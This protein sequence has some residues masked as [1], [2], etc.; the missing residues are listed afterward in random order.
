MKRPLPMAGLM[1]CFVPGMCAQEFDRLNGGAF[2]DYFGSNATGTNMFGVGRRLGFGVFP[3]VKLEDEVAYLFEQEFA[4][5]FTST[6]G[7]TVTFANTGVRA[8]NELFG[9][10]LELGHGN[11][12]PF[13]GIEGR[14][15]GLFV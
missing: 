14:V 4:S 5:G 3:H 2:A 9:P 7:R 15:R 13:F 12:R 10:K 11:F 8:L 1:L 6:S